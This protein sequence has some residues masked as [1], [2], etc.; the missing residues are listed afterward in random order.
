MNKHPLMYI[1][2]YVMPTQE[3]GL[4]INAKP[5]LWLAEVTGHDFGIV[6]LLF[7]FMCML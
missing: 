5:I 6:Y 3:V 4:G 1:I 2:L 7:F